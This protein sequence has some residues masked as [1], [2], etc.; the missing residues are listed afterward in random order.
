MLS[1]HSIAVGE[2]LGAGEKLRWICSCMWMVYTSLGFIYTGN[3]TV[4][5]EH[6]PPTILIWP[7]P[8]KG[9]GLG[10]HLASVLNYIVQWCL[11]HTGLQRIGIM[12]CRCLCKCCVLPGFSV[13]VWRTFCSSSYFTWD[14]PSPAEADC[15]PS[16]RRVWVC[17]S[18]LSPH[19]LSWSDDP[20]FNKPFTVHGSHLE[21]H[22]RNEFMK[23]RGNM[24]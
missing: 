22:A 18:S 5:S 7:G 8:W 13:H 9:R 20:T 17:G 6:R 10:Q 21:G 1:R 16:S 24:G 4:T 14:Y 2:E 15:D 12:C 19:L 23:V 11:P 3:A